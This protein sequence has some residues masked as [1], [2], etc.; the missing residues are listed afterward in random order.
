M[1]AVVDLAKDKGTLDELGFGSIRDA[2]A[3]ML[4]PGTS[5]LHTRVRYA[6][7]VPWL[8]RRAAADGGTAA[9]MTERFADFEVD[10][11]DAL[12][13]GGESRGVVGSESRRKLQRTPASIYM[14]ALSTWEIATRNPWPKAYFRR[15]VDLAH[16]DSGAT[17]ATDDPE[18]RPLTLGDGLDPNLPKAPPD[19]LKTTTFILSPEEREYLVDRITA[20]VPS[21]LLGWL[22]KNPPANLETAQTPWE[23]TQDAPEE[24]AVLVD[25]ARRFSALAHGATLAYGYHVSALGCRRQGEDDSP[26]LSTHDQAISEWES[27]H[28]S[29]NDPETLRLWTQHDWDTFNDN[30]FRIRT[31]TRRFVDEWLRFLDTG[32][33]LTDDESRRI[34]DRRERKLKGGRSRFANRS[35]LDRWS[36]DTPAEALTFRWGVAKRHL[37]DLLGEES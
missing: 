35:A 2:F 18:S 33:S 29:A 20:A 17:K 8:L 19:L 5:T 21:S 11:I 26:A 34:V 28:R 7:L 3:D 4:F 24:L 36:G 14:G 32:G 25:Q 16:L 22:L 27:M 6:L 37:M 12:E 23:L 13:K 30:G 9:A 10:L 31:S 1:L 15:Q